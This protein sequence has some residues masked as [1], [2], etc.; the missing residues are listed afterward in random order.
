[1]WI[2]YNGSV[3][4][5]AEWYNDG[6]GDFHLVADDGTTREVMKISLE[7]L[8]Q[9]RYDEI[10]MSRRPDPDTAVKFGYQL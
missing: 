9:A 1:M 2:V 5:L 6:T 8:R 3:G 7:G 10:P 4:I